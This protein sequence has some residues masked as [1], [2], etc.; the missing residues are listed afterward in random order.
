LAKF[1]NLAFDKLCED[2]NLLTKANGTPDFDAQI[3]LL[4]KYEKNILFSER[5]IA[6]SDSPTEPTKNTGWLTDFFFNAMSGCEK[7]SAADQTCKT[8]EI[9]DLINKLTIQKSK[10]IVIDTFSKFTLEK[11]TFT[12]FENA[13]NNMY[14]NLKATADDPDIQR[15]LANFRQ[16]AFARLTKEVMENPANAIETVIK[17]ST[18]MFLCE[19]IVPASIPIWEKLRYRDTTAIKLQDLESLLSPAHQQKAEQQ[20][21]EL[22]VT[23]G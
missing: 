3:A 14:E 23:N 7:S 9:G 21:G 18:K 2:T 8:K 15:S 4:Q 10:Q 19:P 6:S 22:Q 13:F 11:N 20:T 16:T 1:R 12:D 17:E 5:V